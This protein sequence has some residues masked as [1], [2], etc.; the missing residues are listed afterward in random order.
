MCL[1]GAESQVYDF[2]IWH[3]S[4]RADSYWCGKN[5]KYQICYDHPNDPCTQGHGEWGAGS[6]KAAGMGHYNAL[7]T[8]KMQRYDAD[9][10]GA[11]TLYDGLDC[12]G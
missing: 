10:L 12:V 8:L 5:V 6:A 3:E 1:N 9:A 7:N 4:D 11:V 2:D